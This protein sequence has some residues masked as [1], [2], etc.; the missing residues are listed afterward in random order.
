MDKLPN[1][2][3]ELFYADGDVVRWITR[4]EHAA[5]T[6]RCGLARRDA[7]RFRSK[8]IPYGRVAGGREVHGRGREVNLSGLRLVTS[9]IRAA[10]ADGGRWPW[11]PGAARVAGS[12]SVDDAERLAAIVARVAL[13]DG[14]LTW[15]KSPHSTIPAGAAV[16]GTEFTGA[17]RVM[18]MSGIGY[19]TAD[20]AHALRVG[21]WPW[22]AD[23]A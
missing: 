16:A 19:D 14:A 10:L 9:D 15:I 12:P 13:I 7:A 2:A 1:W 20:V 4:D 8:L 6:A 18:M 22:C 21:D 3:C 11:E 17:R 23:W 5:A